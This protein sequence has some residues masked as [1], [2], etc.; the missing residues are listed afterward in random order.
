M[1][2]VAQDIRSKVESHIIPALLWAMNPKNSDHQDTESASYI[3]LA[4]MAKD[5]EQIEL[6]SGRTAAPLPKLLGVVEL[7]NQRRGYVMPPEN[8]WYLYR[9]KD[10]VIASN[11][12][13]SSTLW[14]DE[15]GPGI[16]MPSTR[17]G[18]RASTARCAVTAESMPPDNPIT[19]PGGRF[20]F[21]K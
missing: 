5:P 12:I 15:Y 3:A 17:S 18:P 9:Y 14:S 6:M 4:K 10:V 19:A 21:S 13:A 11:S 16:A 1:Q 20:C 8:E 2:R 7:D